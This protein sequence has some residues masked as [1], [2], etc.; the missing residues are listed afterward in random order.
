MLDTPTYSHRL[1]KPISTALASALA[2]LQ[3]GSGAHAHFLWQRIHTGSSARTEVTF[4]E[5]P[6]ER[7]SAVPIERLASAR[8]WDATGHPIALSARSGV[9]CGDLPASTRV[10]G[11]SQSWG[12]VD[13]T[14]DGT[15][16]FQLEYY[17]KAAATLADADTSVNLPLEVFAR[18]DASA[19]VALVRRSDG[20]VANASLQV[21]LP[22]GDVLERTTDSDGRVRIDTTTAGAYALRARWIE[23]RSGEL[24]GKKFGEVRHYSTLTF[25]I[26]G[27]PSVSSDGVAIPASAKK[28]ASAP[29]KADPRAYSLLES[30][31]DARQVMP[32][33]YPGFR[34]DLTYREGGRTWSGT[35]TYRRKGET[36]V[37]LEGLGADDVKWVK[38]QLL[39]LTGHRRGGPFAEGDGKYPLELAAEDG[40]PYGQLIVVHD[41][42]DS[43]YRVKDNKVTE[44]T[45]TA[46]G[47]R[48]TISVLETMEA[49]AGRYIANHFLVSYRDEETGA[50]QR[51][52]GYRD[53]YEHMD[54]VW[55][56]TSRTVISV[57]DQTS[58][59]VRT[60]RL[61]KHEVLAKSAQ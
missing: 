2:L 3:L 12:I 50:L 30:A 25:V 29:A 55:I 27:S 11:A 57:G 7:V 10:A 19:L 32:A 54:D 47:S 1:W 20:V 61:R 5:K 39:N 9:L 17:A 44:V 48:F 53:S 59:R 58:P 38:D 4:G 41:A 31:H 6:D 26:A 16:A 24:D 13:R 21:Q 35:L 8:A 33:E 34:C 40:S 56:P 22:S 36:E 18:G 60:I 51:V 14:G 52:D 42:M 23:P 49:D 28:S 45:R 15:G 46:D 37:Q 43:S